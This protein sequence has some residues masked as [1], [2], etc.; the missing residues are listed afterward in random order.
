MKIDHV[1][2]YT[3]NAARTKDWFIDNIGFRAIGKC[4]N[5]HTH[6]EIIALNSAFLVFSSP[7][8]FIS[9]VAQYLNSHPS[10]VVDIAFRV[11]NLQTILKQAKDLGVEV[12]Q[13]SQINQSSPSKYK[14]AKLLGWN[15]L[16]HT[17]IETTAGQP[18]F[19]LPEMIIESDQTASNF[20][21]N[22][23]HIDHIVLNVATGKLNSAVEMYQGL[24]GFKIQQRFQ[25]QTAS[26]GLSSQALV[27]DSG[28]VQFNINEPT[29]ANSQIQEFIDSNNGSGIQHLALRSQNLIADIAQMQQ[30]DICFLTIPQTYYQQLNRLPNLTVAEWQAIAAEQILV[31]SD[32]NHP[33]SLLMQIFTQPIFEQPTFF[34]EF[35]ERRQAATG[36][37]QGNFQ[38]L[39]AAVEREQIKRQNN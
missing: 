33:Q 29:A 38:A 14:Y 27:D 28:E 36:F 8:N 21:T 10:G 35:I 19:C 7:L 4:L 20:A 37:G 9:P 24:F 39:F 34:L 18:D 13:D 11:D 5:Q 3:R 25:I 15:S 22:I 2:F 12:I 1:H 31:D 17:L 6:T 32:P 16:Q 26:S 30:H 23:T